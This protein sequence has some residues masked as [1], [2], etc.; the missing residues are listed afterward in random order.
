MRVRVLRVWTCA[1]QAMEQ[2]ISL[3]IVDSGGGND[4]LGDVLRAAEHDIARETA[5]AVGCACAYACVFVFSLVGATICVNVVTRVVFPYR[6]L[7]VAAN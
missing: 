1:G 6:L 3:E 7:V 5:E 4:E 2:L